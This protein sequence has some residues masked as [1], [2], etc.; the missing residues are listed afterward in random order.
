MTILY[1]Y[2]DASAFLSIVRNRRLWLSSTF[3]MNDLNEGS[4]VEGELLRRMEHEYDA[5]SRENT[6]AAIEVFKDESYACCFSSQA[7]STVQW[8]TYAD[9]GKGF[10]IGFDSRKLMNLYSDRAKQ[11]NVEDCFQMAESLREEN[12][13]SLGPVVYFGHESKERIMDLLLI[14][15]D[16]I[17]PMGN[18][19]DLFLFGFARKVAQFDAVVKDEAF[20]HEREFR[21]TH[22]PEGVSIRT[23]VGENSTK[24][25]S[26][27]GQLSWRASRYGLAPYYEFEFNTDAIEEVWVGPRNPDHANVSARHL[28]STYCVENGISAV[29]IEM[30]KSPYRG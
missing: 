17:R 15:L 13:F 6:L 3:K 27:L 23:L 22:T 9:E 25:E 2:C 30:S 5:S 14:E 19:I 24:R 18:S 26:V 12:C 1:H 21:L 11:F 8:M 20:S 29:R 4:V 7:D 10:A 16:V 28:L